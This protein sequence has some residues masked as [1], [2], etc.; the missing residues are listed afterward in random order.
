MKLGD[1]IS[2]S[3]LSSGLSGLAAGA[4]AGGIPGAVIGGLAGVAGGA[5]ANSKRREGTNASKQAIQTAMNNINAFKLKDYN[6]RIADLKQVQSFY[7]PAMGAWNAAYG[8]GPQPVR[9]Q[10]VGLAGQ[11][12]AG[13]F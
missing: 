13:R 5:Y 9:D 7:A 1:F 10:G 4:I 11:N 3:S 6:Q 12:P 8:T 2:G